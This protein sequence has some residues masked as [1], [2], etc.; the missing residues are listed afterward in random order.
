MATDSPTPLDQIIQA[1]DL[2]SMTPE[3]Q[4]KTMLDLNALIFRGSIMRMIEQMDE[5]TKEAFGKLVESDAAEEELQA[6]LTENVPQA[7]QAVAD[8]VA[9]LTSDILAVTNSK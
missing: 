2:A 7:D 4:E 5:P 8:T 3:E 6:F 1:L 9:A